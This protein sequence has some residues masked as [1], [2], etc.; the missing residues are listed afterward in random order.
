MATPQTNPSFVQRI[1]AEAK[2]APSTAHTFASVPAESGA[3]GGG[4]PILFPTQ[5]TGPLF[6]PLVSLFQGRPR[7]EA[8]F[9]IARTLYR[10]GNPVL[11]QLGLEFLGAAKRGEVL[12]S[13]RD[14]RT[15]FSPEIQAAEKQLLA[16][17]YSPAAV[18]ALSKDIYGSG[19]HLT[20]A[21]LRPLRAEL[22]PPVIPP[23]TPRP[24]QA[25]E[26]PVLAH[27]A[28]RFG[29]QPILGTVGRA[30]EGPLGEMIG[31]E[32]GSLS[33]QFFAQ[34]NPTYANVETLRPQ[35]P[36]REN[37]TPPIVPQP[38]AVPHVDL[39]VPCAACGPLR[40]QETELEQELQ[41]ERQQQQ[42]QQQQE[43]QQQI[44]RLRQLERLPP[45][46]R[47]IPAELAQKQ[48]LLSRI[49]GEIAQMAQAETPQGAAFPVHAAGEVPSLPAEPA[50]PALA[51]LAQPAQ[52]AHTE[53]V[54]LCLMCE[55][56]ADAL[57][58]LN[59]Q[60]ASCVVAE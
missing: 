22:Q 6:D 1:A 11:E 4:I 56:Q 24:P 34:I 16:M 31:E 44:E 55:T 20:L 3:G 38:A 26:P 40:E 51:Q 45:E 49:Q 25:T 48:Q 28:P 17:G 10:S 59:G 2:L 29:A 53:P 46:Q 30:L 19:G 39:N 54:R 23:P 47:N 43:Q 13:R 21:E 9:E 27:R 5:P 33:D 15:T 32:L 50:Q 37:L 41:T 58:F 18:A 12:S 36:T 14:I 60:P 52:P 57:K 42:E 35:R 8:T 7:S